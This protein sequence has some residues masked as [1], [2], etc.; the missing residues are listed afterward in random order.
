M[1]LIKGAESVGIDKFTYLK[2]TSCNAWLQDEKYRDFVSDLLKNQIC[3]D[4]NN[5]PYITKFFSKKIN[6]V[7]E[8]MKMEDI[9]YDVFKSHLSKSKIVTY[10]F[11]PEICKYKNLFKFDEIL[12]RELSIA[13]LVFCSRE[14]KQ[15]D[16][17]TYISNFIDDSSSFK[18]MTD[19]ISLSLL[20]ITSSSSSVYYEY[21]KSIYNQTYIQAFYIAFKNT[22]ANTKKEKNSLR[23]RAKC[24]YELINSL[25]DNPSKVLDDNFFN[26]IKRASK[27][28]ATTIRKFFTQLSETNACSFDLVSSSFINN[29]FVVK[30]IEEGFDFVKYVPQNT[31]PKL[32][33]LVVYTNGYRSKNAKEHSYFELNTSSIKNPLYKSLFRRYIWNGSSQE[34]SDRTDHCEILLN[35]IK[36][37]DDENI[38]S[39]KYSEV[40]ISMKDTISKFSCSQNSIRLKVNVAIEFFEYYKDILSINSKVFDDIKS[41]F[42]TIATNPYTENYT[43]EEIESFVEECEKRVNAATKES[44][45]ETWII[46]RLLI[47]IF[48]NSTIRIESFLNAS[49][50]DLQKNTKE[51]RFYYTFTGKTKRELKNGYFD[52]LVSYYVDE[53]VRISEKYRWKTEEFSHSMILYRNSYK[54]DIIEPYTGKTLYTRIK[55]LCNN[56]NIPFRAKAGLRNYVTESNLIESI[57]NGFNDKEQVYLNGHSTKEQIKSYSTVNILNLSRE[58]F[59]HTIGSMDFIKFN[60]SYDSELFESKNLVNEGTGY[61]DSNCIDVNLNCM[62]CPSFHVTVKNLSSFLKLEEKLIKQYKEYPV[63]DN[64]VLLTTCQKYINELRNFI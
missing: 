51:N 22:K 60:N 36:D 52:Y 10:D 58:C 4:I 62:F 34:L 15:L 23:N 26:A 30:K 42:K 19:K 41:S 5:E 27:D 56:L 17:M 14:F 6:K 18:E 63:Q 46:T 21:L 45:K 50:N 35:L 38:Y 33:K 44:E 9:S 7:M 16:D 37:K 64:Y 29:N 8:L 53:I 13:S 31:P 55:T 47:L 11:L 24:V 32:D 59:K 2:N 40:I 3:Y 57:E 48:S 20:A 1:A 39:F 28:N 25:P 49:I 61:C 12:H 54:N 43:R